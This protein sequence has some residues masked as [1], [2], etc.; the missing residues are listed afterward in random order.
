MRHHPTSPVGPVKVR[1]SDVAGPATETRNRSRRRWPLLAA[2][3]AG[4]LLLAACSVSTNPSSTN[5]SS[6]VPASSPASAT[7]TPGSTLAQARDFTACM[8]AH[9]VPDFPRPTVKN[10]QISFAGT[11]G[12]GRTPD[13]ASAQQTCSLSIYGMTPTQGSQSG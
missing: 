12:I 10:G 7:A 11:A 3:I 5:P 2:V 4:G 8:R 6:A 1:G 13:F 9:G